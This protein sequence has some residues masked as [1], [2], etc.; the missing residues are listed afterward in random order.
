M[1]TYWLALGLLASS[2]EPPV[3]TPA[4]VGGG[5]SE[6]AEAEWLARRKWST[7]IERLLQDEAVET[8]PEGSTTQAAQDAP[9]EPRTAQPAPIPLIASEAVS[10]LLRA[11]QPT[12]HVQAEIDAFLLALARR[13]RQRAIEQAIALEALRIEQ[14]EEAVLM[15]LLEVA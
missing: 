6:G 14:D 1:I 9:R 4:A 15:L 2:A 12:A 3:E 8:A 11:L 13:D 10:G 5:S 7:E